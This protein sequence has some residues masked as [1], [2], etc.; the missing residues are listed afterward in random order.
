MSLSS[1]PNLSYSLNYE[2]TCIM[3]ASFYNTLVSYL[4]VSIS[5]FLQ[6]WPLKCG[7]ANL[8]HVTQQDNVACFIIAVFLNTLYPYK[9]IMMILI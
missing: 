5:P 7:Y 1:F 8:F 4:R 9:A 6:I 2:I 3:Q